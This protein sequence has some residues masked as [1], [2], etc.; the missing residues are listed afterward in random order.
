MIKNRQINPETCYKSAEQRAAAYFRSLW[1][2]VNDKSY[3]PALA[4]DFG[5]WKQSHVHSPF[6][7]LFARGSRQPSQKDYHYYIQWLDYRG[8]LDDYLDRSISYLF[9]RDLGKAL[10]SEDTREKIEKTFESLKSQLTE[11][12]KEKPVLFSFHSVYRQ[13]QEE[14]IESTVIWLFGKLRRVTSQMP[15]GLDALNAQRKLLKI[16]AGVLMH[17]IIDMDEDTAPDERRKKL[18]DAIR[19]GYSYGLT[20]PF[21]DDLLDAK[22]LSDEEAGRY[23]ELIRTALITGTVPELDE[24]EGEN[25]ELVRF[26]HAELSEAFEMIKAHQRPER[27]ASFFEQAYVFF[28]SQEEDRQK[29][30]SYRDYSNEDLY[31]PVILK[32]SSSRL[33]VRSV[34]DAPED[35]GFDRRT[36]YYGIYNQLADDFADMFDDLEEGAVTPYTYYLRY[37][38]E[39]PDLINPF[40][41][42]W[43]VISNLIH[44]VYKSDPKAREVI[45]DRAINGLKRYKERMGKDKYNEVMEL[46]ASRMP[47]FNRMIQKFVKKA[48][49]VD[50]YDKLLRDHMLGNLRKDRD[51]LETFRESVKNMRS[52]IN[53]NLTLQD[54]NR[55]DEHI[56]EAVNY[57]LEGEGKRLRPVI[58]WSMGADGYG[59]D[60]E[61]IIPLLKSLEFMH[62]ASLIFDDLPAQDNAP[63]R[64]GRP[65]LHEA[66]NTATAELSAL[67]LTQKAIEEQTFLEQFDAKTILKL[68]RYSA[69]TTMD[70]CKGQAM[71]LESKGK[72]LTLEQLKTLCFYKTA[73][74]FEASLLMPALLAVADQSEMQALKDFAR[75]AG[76]A[77][78][79]KDDLLDAEGN[80]NT[81]GK[82]AKQDL[83]N[84]SSTFVTV[85]GAEEAKKEMWN[86]YCLAMEVLPKI[87]R[88]TVFLE[89]LL[90]YMVNRES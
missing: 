24:W 8:K 52:E 50:F 46:F 89:H 16:I 37:H 71:D 87:P 41:L 59:L 28:Q 17:V 38:Q 42:Y 2:Q 13:A 20:Y 15:E 39:R 23:S 18:E 44:S 86:Q 56:L 19:L 81:I 76:V 27:L 6:L 65:T 57:S 70:M 90:K 82:P 85:L 72:K 68:I 5:V 49:N 35:E 55:L 33:I 22:L 43:T 88:N 21:I 36:F 54:P 84:G 62:T 61:A 83:E 78:Q 11:S 7:S 10:D 60:K 14:G 64:R 9:M 63:T 29:T 25:E 69:R 77:F 47:D 66:Y 34:I 74:A 40:E 1:E 3:M 51:D 48:D 67:F 80:I 32:S 45:L 79:I 12:P 73:I 75:H 4:S 26:I 31:I 58:A 53:K 30:L